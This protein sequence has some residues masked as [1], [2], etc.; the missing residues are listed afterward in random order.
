MKLILLL[1]TN[2]AFNSGLL[3]HAY[4]TTWFKTLG[5][6]DHVV[7]CD[8][9]TVDEALQIVDFLSQNE[10][11]EIFTPLIDYTLI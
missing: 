1:K 7:N 2:D 3:D 11:I 5:R 4:V 9:V 6:Y 10:G 8:S